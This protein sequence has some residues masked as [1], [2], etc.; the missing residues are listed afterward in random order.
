MELEASRPT[1]RCCC[2]CCGAVVLLCIII[3]I[4]IYYRR[5]TRGRAAGCHRHFLRLCLCADSN[6]KD[7]LIKLS[8]TNAQPILVLGSDQR[9]FEINVDD[10]CNN[11]VSSRLVLR[12][13]IFVHFVR[14]RELKSA[15][16]KSVSHGRSFVRALLRN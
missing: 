14:A 9:D 11:A 2:C 3:I 15:G 13:I 6:Q 1:T 5:V 4:V 10:G 7:H 8:I 16:S 12:F